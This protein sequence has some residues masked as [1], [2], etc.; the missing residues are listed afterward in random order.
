M[1]KFPHVLIVEDN[2][3]T[4]YI[5]RQLMEAELWNATPAYTGKAAQDL[6]RDNVYQAILLDYSLPDVEGTE[7]I[8]FCKLLHP[9]TPIL[10][11]TGY[12]EGHVGFEV[13][14]AGADGFITKGSGFPEIK[15]AIESLLIHQKAIKT[16]GKVLSKKDSLAHIIGN[17]KLINDLKS[18]I[19]TFADTNTSTLIIGPNGSGKEAVA[20]GLHALSRRAAMPFIVD[21]AAGGTIELS[22]SRY[23]GHYKGAFTGADADYLGTFRQADKGTV[24]I[25][26]IGN[27]VLNTQ[28]KMLR[29]T[30]FKEVIPLGI[31]AK[32]VKVDVRLITA[33][34]K[35]LLHEIEKGT[36]MED[37]YHRISTVIIEVPSLNARIEDL[38]LL[39]EHFIKK[40][41]AEER[42]NHKELAQ[43]SL[44]FMMHY[45]WTG[46]VRELSNVLHN[47]VIHAGSNEV[48]YMKNLNRLNLK[49]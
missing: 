27:M 17:S 49:R 10:M 20:A 47:A 36:F 41:C 42:R 7:L 43:E 5:L 4:S 9:N 37:F 39:A 8:K 22:D 19:A 46:N 48:I 13:S 35:N 12:D 23:F 25:D 24:F 2:K 44:D 33:T 32:P 16:S 26:E 40:F 28:Q 45:N 14:R 34:N 3:D 31:K 29:A 30:Q 21:N 18:D 38:P 6:L 15:E 1:S 11:H